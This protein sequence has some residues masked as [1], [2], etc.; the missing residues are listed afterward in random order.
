MKNREQLVKELEA[1]MLKACK[2]SERILHRYALRTREMIMYYGPVEAA[3]KLIELKQVNEGFVDLLLMGKA[4]LTAEYIIN[5][6]KYAT[7]FE[8]QFRSKA[9][10]KISFACR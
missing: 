3:K 4:K 5:K 10:E 7:L 2:S 6:K 9:W 8:E 1:D